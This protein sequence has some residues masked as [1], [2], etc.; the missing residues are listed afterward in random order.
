MKKYLPHF[1]AFVTSSTGITC[2]EAI[3]ND[4]KSYLIHDQKEDRWYEATLDGSHWDISNYE[5]IQEVFWNKK[6]GGFFV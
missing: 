6:T 3:V 5:K 2:G 4:K 1:C